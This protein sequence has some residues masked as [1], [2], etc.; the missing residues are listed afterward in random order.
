M[1]T[2]K[3]RN[4]SL[5]ISAVVPEKILSLGEFFFRRY[6]TEYTFA[7]VRMITGVV[8]LSSY[9]HGCWRKILHLFEMHIKIACLGGQFSHIYLSTSGMRGYEIGYQLLP[10]TTRAVYAFENLSEFIELTERR[11]THDTQDT[12][13]SMFLSLIHISEPTR[14]S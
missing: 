10:Q 11:L 3:R 12:I 13:A 9:R 4:D 6:S 8:Y 2:A 1:E 7:G 5:T 14:R